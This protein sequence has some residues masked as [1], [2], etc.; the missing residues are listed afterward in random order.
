MDRPRRHHVVGTMRTPLE[1]FRHR[2][3]ADR[4]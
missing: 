4:P 3:V 2:G 1:R